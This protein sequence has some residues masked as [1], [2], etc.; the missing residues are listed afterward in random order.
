M[1][2]DK[3][4]HW[5]LVIGKCV[6]AYNGTIHATTCFTP[7][8]LWYGRELFHSADM[9]MP[10]MPLEK[11]ESMVEYVQR[12]DSDVRLAYQIAR[13]TIGKNM[14]IQ[15]KY[16]DRSSNLVHYKEGDQIMLKDFTPHI[17]GEKKL[18]DKWTGPLFVLDAM[19]DVN[20]RVIASPL[21]KEKVVH[22]DRMK[23]YHRRSTEPMNLDWLFERSRT[24]KQA[25]DVTNAVVPGDAAASSGNPTPA[26]TLQPDAQLVDRPQQENQVPVDE[27]AADV[28]PVETGQGGG[29]KKKKWKLRVQ[30][31]PRETVCSKRR[32]QPSPKAEP[33]ADIVPQPRRRGRPR[34]NPVPE[35]EP[36][37]PVKKRRSSRP[38][39]KCKR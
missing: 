36:P 38:S 26:S 6:S 32:G 23:R 29:S 35:P 2:R 10:N 11:H 3:S 14:K 30:L 7:N 9:M 24:H 34:K 16:Y 33:T 12:W 15:K 19:S 21:G 5:D 4:Y 18:A 8:K 1:L 39:R 28:A 17:R 37:E 22:H 25:L 31:K 13:E 20:F 27:P